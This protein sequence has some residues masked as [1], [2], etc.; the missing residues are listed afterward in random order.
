ML[1]EGAARSCWGRG[2]EIYCEKLSLDA[3]K[4][5]HRVHYPILSKA[6]PNLALSAFSLFFRHSIEC[7]CISKPTPLNNESRSAG[8]WENGS[9]R[10]K[11]ESSSRMAWSKKKKIHNFPIL[12]FAMSFGVFY[13]CELCRPGTFCSYRNWIF[14]IWDGWWWQSV[15]Q[16]N[17]AQRRR[18]HCGVVA[19]LNFNLISFKLVDRAFLHMLWLRCRTA[20]CVYICS[21]NATNCGACFCC[22]LRG[23]QFSK[24]RVGYEIFHN[25]IYSL[26]RIFTLPR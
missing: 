13:F 11:G 7:V 3:R 21:A 23:K 17:L 20:D 16:T 15:S 22:H 1:W 24:C 12:A 4:S 25:K 5:P 14:S 10:W 9:S 18:G 26:A 19:G 2:A 8:V 6:P